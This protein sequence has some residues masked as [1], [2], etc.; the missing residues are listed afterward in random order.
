MIGRFELTGQ[1][2]LSEA[3][4]AAERRDDPRRAT[5]GRPADRLAITDCSPVDAP[6]PPAGVPAGRLAAAAAARTGL[7]QGT[8]VV[9][10]LMDSYAA[11]LA[12]DV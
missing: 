5:A 1:C 8:P 6:K 9:Q 3:T 7:T 4:I 10:G 2:N 12:A 11:A